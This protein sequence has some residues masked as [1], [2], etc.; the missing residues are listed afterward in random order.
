MAQVRDPQSDAA[1]VPAPAA[2]HRSRPLQR[3]PR[4]EALLAQLRAR[5]ARGIWFHGLGTL[6]AVGS[7]WL[8]WCY[9]A[10][11]VLRVP[12]PV[13]AL[14][15]LAWF[16]LTAWVAW[17]F[18][19]QPLRRIPDRS[20]LA[21]LAELARSGAQAGPSDDLLVSAVELQ[22][23]REAADVARDPARAELVT[24]VLARAEQ[25]AGAV[26]LERVFEPRAV[27]ARLW[28][29]LASA[30]VL[31][32]LAALDP[33]SARLFA[34]RFWLSSKPWPQATQLCFQ[35]QQGPGALDAGGSAV[36]GEIFERGRHEIQVAR[37]AD[38]ALAVL[39][40][41]KV[42][43]SVELRSSSGSRELLA[44]SSGGTF[45]ALLRGLREPVEIHAVGGDDTD[46]EPTLV[47]QVLDAPDVAALA[48]AI[49]PPA[50]SGLPARAVE[51]GQDV[52]VLAGS[53][54]RVVMRPQPSDASAVARLLPEDRL[55]EL[56]PMPWPF[57]PSDAPGPL[58]AAVEAATE[59]LGFQLV[60]ERSL[61]YRFELRSP[62][63]L[64]NPS[65]GLYSIDVQADRKPQV[66]W[67]APAR[68]EIDQVIGGTLRLLGRAEDDFGVARVELSV[69]RS[70]TAEPHV[71]ELDCAPAE[72]P[73]GA[74]RERGARALVAG[75]RLELGQWFAPDSAPAPHTEG[76][77]DGD[78]GALSEGDVLELEL[79]AFD[80]CPAPQ[81]QVSRT[82]GLRV[83]LVS[84]EEF[85]RRLQD[86]LS[87]TRVKAAE[88]EVLQRA[89]TARTRE[90]LEALGTQGSAP[91]EAA[92]SLTAALAGQRRAQSDAEALARE[93][94]GALEN[95]LYARIDPMG[96]A[97]LELLDRRLA[98]ARS[99][100][101]QWSAFQAVVEGDS[102]AV[103]ASGTG[104]SAQ[105]TPMVGLGLSLARKD[106]NAA[107]AALEEASRLT[108]ASEQSGALERA[109]EHQ[110]QAEARLAEL[111]ERLSEWDNFQ[112]VLTLSREILS[113]Q[114][115]LKERLSKQPEPAK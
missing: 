109:R 91:T 59:G 88:L 29:G 114:K 18:G 104:L 57:A 51:G 61:R 52:Q 25:R 108:R 90:L 23:T 20:G 72:N 83:R 15:L 16:V 30:G 95:V 50:Y 99:R 97:A 41:G 110:L 107:V 76:G 27:R 68:S 81:P 79:A 5:L 19:W 64:E 10:D 56:S 38:V 22:S 89:R 21:L 71:M 36:A 2:G 96:E 9:V 11:R 48:V 4:L 47:I 100:G 45:R 58:D 77:A 7:A 112:S 32:L 70:G 17:R 55:L 42:P 69:R 24:S 44:A 53:T 8:L 43:R 94:A 31:V 14:H 92:A 80:Q 106:T 113:R 26:S 37:G 111:V 74:E 33:A 63:G 82:P 103:G 73:F 6:A 35:V 12:T 78:G 60:A 49:Q 1:P 34:A 87:R 102:T 93:L 65:P 115:S 66:E 85:L 13:R 101:F 54:L 98:S 3:T 28:L 86:R 62:E 105:L 84:Q 40:R 46:R 39:A 67:L 75:V